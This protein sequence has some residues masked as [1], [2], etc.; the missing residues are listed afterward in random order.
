MS[1]EDEVA[2][3]TGA[4]S[5]IGRTIALELARRGATVVGVGRDPA[6][7]AALKAELAA[8]SDANH[9]AIAA[10]VASEADMERVKA[11][12]AERGGVEVC[13][14][15]AVAKI[16]GFPPRTKD[17]SLAD[18][19]TQIDVNLNGVFLAN[20]ICIDMMLEQGDGD[21][22]NIASSTTPDGLKGT[23]MAPAYCA[24]KFAISAYSKTIA[25]ELAE[26]GIRVHAFHPGAID[27]P[28]IANTSLGM[29]YGGKMSP[30][31]VAVALV[32]L[33]ELGREMGIPEPF[34][35]PV[36]QPRAAPATASEDTK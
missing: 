17:L 23:P 14:A 1:F 20:K 3:V 15:S 12:L 8:I 16:P 19:N 18:W 7:L 36:P 4:T 25:A 35:L 34:F 6:R 32:G 22:V 5:G 11:A 28:L 31:S 24:S 26:E 21:I 30:E 10:D 27:T 33:I 2:L 13:V 9:A 29:A